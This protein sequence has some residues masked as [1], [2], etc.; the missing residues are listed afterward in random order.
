MDLIVTK[1]LTFGTEAGKCEF[2]S[3]KFS[4][5]EKNPLDNLRSSPMIVSVI[6]EREY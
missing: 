3:F 6:L 5:R 1:E 4:V 2:H